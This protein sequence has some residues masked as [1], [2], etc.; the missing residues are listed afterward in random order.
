MPA[1]KKSASA[2]K[3]KSVAKQIIGS[4][5]GVRITLDDSPRKTL[6]LETPGGHK[7]TL[8]DTPMVID[9]TDSS[10]NTVKLDPSGI[11]I[12]ASAKVTIFAA[13]LKV[14]ASAVNIDSPVSKFSGAIQCDTLV[15][16]SVAS[17]SYTPG[18]GNIW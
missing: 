8:S 11:T 16:N 1:K 7:I 2:A 12:R 13:E 4:S 10:G 18:A 3:T 17:A 6:T 5:E 14:N 15:T 9:I